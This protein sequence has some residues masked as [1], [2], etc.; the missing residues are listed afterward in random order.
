M[1]DI[2]LINLSFRRDGVTLFE[3]VT[4]DLTGSK[5]IAILAD[6]EDTAH[7]L[8]RSIAGFLCPDTGEVLIGGKSFYAGNEEERSMIMR[9]NS[10]VFYAGGL[11][12]NLSVLENIMLP[13]DF[14]R[15]Q[16]TNDEKMEKITKLV[17]YFELDPEIIDKRP[18]QLSRPELKII[19]FV[20]AY[21]IEPEAIMIESPFSRLNKNYEMLIENIILESAFK[22][23]IVHLFSQGFESDLIDKSDTI[24]AMNEG[25]VS[26]FSKAAGSYDEFNFTD[27]FE[28]KRV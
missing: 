1:I 8:L 19:N 28:N 25:K 23:D 17:S 3:D 21:V 24:F 4:V 14:R 10:Y 5:L 6:T 13:L 11:I 16:L 18:S 27:F 12:S 20:R 7:T 2:E 15:H 9:R 26:I 22:K